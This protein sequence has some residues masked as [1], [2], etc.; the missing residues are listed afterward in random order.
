MVKVVNSFSPGKRRH[1]PLHLARIPFMLTKDI[2][3]QNTFEINPLSPND[4][5]L[6]HIRILLCPV[7]CKFSSVS[8]LLLSPPL[9]RQIPDEDLFALSIGECSFHLLGSI[10]ADID[11]E[12]EF[13][14]IGKA[15]RIICLVVGL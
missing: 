13:T 12:P 2:V 10:V 6:V 15:R 1:P 14:P 4:H 5:T 11:L 3:D 8:D 9:D 7:D